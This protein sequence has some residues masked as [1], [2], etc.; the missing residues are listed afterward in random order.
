MSLLHLPSELLILVVT[1]LDVENDINS[2]AQTNK[3]F[4]S[5]LKPIPLSAKLAQRWRLGTTM[6]SSARK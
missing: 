4:Y 3:A 6:G 2:L 1:F 5:L